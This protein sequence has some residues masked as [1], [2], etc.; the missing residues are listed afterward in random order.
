MVFKI[1]RPT[2]ADKMSTDVKSAI[3]AQQ[4]EMAG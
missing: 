3:D 4:T 2:Q 1:M